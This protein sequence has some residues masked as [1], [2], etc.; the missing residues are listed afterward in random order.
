ML[1]LITFAILIGIS[2]QQFPVNLTTAVFQKYCG[3]PDINFLSLATVK[4]DVIILS[5]D[6]QLNLSNLIVVKNVIYSSNGHNYTAEDSYLLALEAK[7]RFDLIFGEPN[8]L[9]LIGV[10]RS[11]MFTNFTRF[12]LDDD[13]KIYEEIELLDNDLLEVRSIFQ[14]ETQNKTFG[15]IEFFS[16]TNVKGKFIYEAIIRRNSS[17]EFYRRDYENKFTEVTLKVADDA[18]G[19][20]KSSQVNSRSIILLRKT[21]KGNI[22][23]GFP[24]KVDTSVK[25][26]VT[27]SAKYFLLH[28]MIGC[29]PSPCHVDGI[30][31]TFSWL[32]RERLLINSWS[33]AFDGP[34]KAVNYLSAQSVTRGRYVFYG[35]R[36]VPAIFRNRNGTSLIDSQ[37]TRLAH[38]NGTAVDVSYLSD[39]HEQVKNKVFL[40]QLPVSPI[41]YVDG[42]P[43]VSVAL[44]FEAFNDRTD[45]RDDAIHVVASNSDDFIPFNHNTTYKKFFTTDIFSPLPANLKMAAHVHGAHQ[46]EEFAY[47]FV[48]NYYIRFVVADVQFEVPK[49]APDTSVSPPRCFAEFI[50]CPKKILPTRPTSQSSP[51]DFPCQGTP[52]ES[53]DN[54]N[55]S[56]SDN[57]WLYII[58]ILL[59]T[60]I[61][62]TIAY[63]IYRRL[64]PIH[65]RYVSQSGP[66]FD[67]HGKK[68]KTTIWS[69]S[70]DT[71]TTTQTQG[72]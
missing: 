19:F 18:I 29:P 49:M 64:Q 20:I 55:F 13:E 51:G 68:I 1:S 24:A 6:N 59:L 33:F 30:S 62:I 10:T 7:F 28:D 67:S 43:A 23:S 4:N 58:L 65:H 57:M 2:Q 15:R 60:V 27:K 37:T 31:G 26:I 34:G 50:G 46:G 72:A 66:G 42:K 47:V 22:V 69:K 3:N 17:I 14:Q 52:K 36:F 48:H 38:L 70:S 54:H 21:M 41:M 45:K 8:T 32:G 25:Q 39:L 56:E 63:L 11:N 12:R 5:R 9:Y 35:P 16:A 44:S 61:S 53:W 40:Y 71:H